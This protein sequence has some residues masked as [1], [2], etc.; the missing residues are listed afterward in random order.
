MDGYTIVSKLI[1]KFELPVEIVVSDAFTT[2]SI[3][4]EKITEEDIYNIMER[5][6]RELDE[7]N[8]ET[9]YEERWNSGSYSYYAVEVYS[10]DIENIEDIVNRIITNY[11][12]KILDEEDCL[13]FVIE[14][15]IPASLKRTIEDFIRRYGYNDIEDLQESLQQNGSRIQISVD[16]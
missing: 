7:N 12:K 8:Y 9:G 16:T 6:V 1:E 14:I 13:E 15:H 10:P 11:S 4:D 2:S 5:I 3:C